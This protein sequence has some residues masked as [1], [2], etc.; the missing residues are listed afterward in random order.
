MGSEMCIR[1]RVKTGYGNSEVDI[2]GTSMT[3]GTFYHIVVTS[4]TGGTKTY[5]NGS[6]VS[7]QSG[8]TLIG[9]DVA[10]GHFGASS[11]TDYG[12]YAGCCTV[13]NVFITYDEISAGAVTSLYNSTT[14]F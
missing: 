14:T 13:D 9:A 1:D 11:G 7:T 3:A 12:N 10:I 2:V 5:F 8:T 4:G 6:L